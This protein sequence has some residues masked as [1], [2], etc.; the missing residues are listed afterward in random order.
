MPD[1]R[2]RGPQQVSAVHKNTQSML[3]N[4]MTASS[5]NNNPMPPQSHSMHLLQYPQPGF[6][7]EY[8][9]VDEGS[10]QQSISNTL[11][12]MSTQKSDVA[13]LNKMSHQMSHSRQNKLPS[14]MNTVGTHPQRQS[15][16][17]RP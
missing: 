4:V 13:S 5:R 7:A 17:H 10:N 12:Q 8:G 9:P 14:K 2:S 6:H 3:S 16:G 11:G 1:Q 15:V